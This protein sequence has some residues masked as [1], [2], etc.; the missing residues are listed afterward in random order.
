[1]RSILPILLI[2]FA[3][4]HA[5][6]AADTVPAFN[7]AMTC[8]AAV[9]ISPGRAV[10]TCLRD[11]ADARTQL[12]QRWSGFPAKDRTSCTRLSLLDGHPSYVEV[13]TC[14]EI[15]EEARNVRD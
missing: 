5:A 15:A 14:L 6:R 11:E 3:A 4:A 1:M 9:A 10:D 12:E 13:L 8:R 7:V 2:L